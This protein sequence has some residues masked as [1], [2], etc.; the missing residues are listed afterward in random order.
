MSILGAVVLGLA[1]VVTVAS[2]QEVK[3]PNKI[4]CQLE[5]TAGSRIPQR[6]CRTAAQWAER[7]EADQNT[8]KGAMNQNT[9]GDWTAQLPH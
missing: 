8:L 7:A 1:P 6:I 2:P 3:D 4:V 5:F 9:S